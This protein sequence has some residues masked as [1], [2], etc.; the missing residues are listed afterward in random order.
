MKE[1]QDINGGS[2]TIL[3]EILPQKVWDQLKLIYYSIYFRFVRWRFKNIGRQKS[4]KDKIRVAFFI[5]RESVWKYDGVYRLMEKHPRFECV[6]VVI[7]NIVYGDE[8][9]F[10]EM[11]KT[12]KMC[13]E[14][15][16]NVVSTY[17]LQNQKWLDIK[18]EINP[19]IVFFHTPYHF[20]TKSEYLISNFRDRLSCYV[21]YTFQ[22]TNQY[23]GQYNR[24]LHNN[25]WKAYYQTNIHRQIAVE[26]ALN[27]GRNVVVTGYP[28]IDG[29][30]ESNGHKQDQINQKGLKNII[31]APH[32]TI[33]GNG[34]GLDFSNFIRYSNFIK[35]LS[36]ELKNEVFITFKPHP[37][38]KHKLYQHKDWG[39]EKTNK[40]FEFW[41]KNDFCALNEGNYQQL[42][43]DSDAMIHDSDSFMGEY[44]SMNKPVLYTLRDDHVKNRLNNFGKMALDMHYHARNEADIIDFINNVVM[45]KKDIM[46]ETRSKFI[47]E[48]IVPPNSGTAS[49]NILMDITKSLNL[50]LI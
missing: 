12:F 42:F 27:R 23:E 7:P 49:L 1:I 38:L 19:D 36:I 29:F 4:K 43:Q 3:R 20:Y 31:W 33:E 32:H 37:I 15:G 50:D 2:F 44:L 34:D 35:N 14:K 39:I 41:S 21:P 11:G 26:N 47:S 45:N 28:G 9:M 48:F 17:N 24:Y 18:K 46:K 6:V 40:Y 22:T 13:K 25:V 5:S 16:Y 10:Q 30:L 8:Y